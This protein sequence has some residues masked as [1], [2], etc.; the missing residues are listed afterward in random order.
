MD[1]K[2]K[3]YFKIN[4]LPKPNVINYVGSWAR[5]DCYAVTCGWFRIKKY[6]VYCIKDEIH[7]VRRR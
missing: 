1:E 4:K 7:S 5:G 3:E 6:C 2:I